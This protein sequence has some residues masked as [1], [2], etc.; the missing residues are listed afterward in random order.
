MLLSPPVPTPKIICKAMRKRSA[1]GG[2]IDY[3]RWGQPQQ[4]IK[5]GS[6]TVMICGSGLAS[7]NSQGGDQQAHDRGH[8]AYYSPSTTY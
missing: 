2:S 8:L 7:K 6:K 4:G 5:V 1:I 3:L